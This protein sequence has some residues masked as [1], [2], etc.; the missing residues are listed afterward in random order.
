[1]KNETLN[2]EGENVKYS[3]V[4]DRRFFLMKNL[5]HLQVASFLRNVSTTPTQCWLFDHKAIWW[6]LQGLQAGVKTI[7]DT[8]A[9]RSEKHADV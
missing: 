3:K 5:L 1:M 9:V 2:V 6:H 4:D 8:V 7:Y